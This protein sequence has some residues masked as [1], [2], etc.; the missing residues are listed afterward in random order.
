MKTK[1]LIIIC[2]F[3]LLSCMEDEDR[4][5]FGF[6]FTIANQSGLE[7]ENV[8]ITIGGMENG[9]FIGTDSYTFPKILVLSNDWPDTTGTQS[10]SFAFYEERWNPDL[11]SVKAI[12]DKAY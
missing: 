10:Q 7:H 6:T 4:D 3:S 11:A 12:S 9:E 2:C 1:L 5:Q 8:K